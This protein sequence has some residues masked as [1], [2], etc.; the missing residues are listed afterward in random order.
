M[1]LVET[2]MEDAL[3]ELKEKYGAIGVKAE[4]ETEGL[5]LEEAYRLKDLAFNAGLE[6]TIKIGGCG[7]VKDL[8]EIYKIRKNSF[9]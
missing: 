5:Y 8:N 6:T 4:F 3:Y 2:M 7:A 9:F 1:N